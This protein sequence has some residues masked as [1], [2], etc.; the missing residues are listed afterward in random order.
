MRV[1][2]VLTEAGRPGCCEF[3]PGHQADVQAVLP[4]VATVK[5]RCGLTRV[6]WVAARGLISADTIEKLEDQEL[7]DIL[8][9]RLRRHKEVR[10]LV[11]GCPGRS[12]QVA[13]HL[14]VQEVWVQGRR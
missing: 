14:R 4:V 11:R 8:G 6:C 13:D 3:W 5:P 2:A 1:G 10:D 7:E 9:A 12:R